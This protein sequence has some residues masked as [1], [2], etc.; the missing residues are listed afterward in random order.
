MWKKQDIAF[1][2]EAFCRRSPKEKEESAMAY[3]FED[4]YEATEIDD[5]DEV[6]RILQKQPDLIH[7][8]DEYEFSILHAAVMT[9]DEELLEWLIA[10]GA[11]VHA[12][13]DEGITP[14]HIVL[15]PEIAALLIRHGANVNAAAHDGS[16]PLHTQVSDGEERLDV[17]EVL[18]AHGADKTQKDDRGQTPLDIALERE[19][20]EIAQL[21]GQ[22]E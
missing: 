3:T 9:E 16:A 6:K 17:I 12:K 10:K 5:F 21:L 22:A 7:G 8:K 13:N 15:Y 14:L 2:A 18:L 1:F 20:K 4:L 19:E 11:D